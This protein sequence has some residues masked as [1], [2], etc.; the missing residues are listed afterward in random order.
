MPTINPYV[1]EFEGRRSVPSMGGVGVRTPTFH[2]FHQ[3]SK[4]RIAGN[5]TNHIYIIEN[6]S[7][8]CS[9]MWLLTLI[10]NHQNPYN[11]ANSS[12]L[13]HRQH[14]QSISPRQINQITRAVP[15]SHRPKL[16]PFVVKFHPTPQITLPL[17]I[18]SQIYS[19]HYFCPR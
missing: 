12:I 10:V 5:R 4:L 13:T 11:T 14:R 6:K 18:R 1:G 17:T 15:P 8:I 9:G 2:A 19:S 7:R 3:K 16:L